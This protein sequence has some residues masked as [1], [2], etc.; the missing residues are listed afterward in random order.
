MPDENEAV[1][2]LRLLTLPPDSLEVQSLHPD[3]RALVQKVRPWIAGPNVVGTGVSFK[4]VAGTNTNEVALRVYVRRKIKHDHVSRTHRV[5]GQVTIPGLSA[6]LPTDV[7]EIGIVRLQ[8]LSTRQRPILPGYSVGLQG[9]STGSIACFVASANAPTVPLLLSNSHVLAEAGIAAAGGLVVQPGSDDGADANSVVGQLLKW[10]PFDF[11]AGFN[12]LCD[13][14]LASI[15]TG[16]DVINDIPTI[17][18][19]KPP[20]AVSA[21]KVG[22]AVQKTGRTTGHTT[23][24]VQDVHFQNTM[25]YPEP[26]GGSGNAGF[27]EQVLCSRYS[28][29]GD[30][31]SLICDMAGVAIG[32]HWAGSTA[33]SI[34]SPI[35]FVFQQLAVELWTQHP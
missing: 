33:A 22:D 1:Q 4:Q 27:H 12:N 13:A 5:P 24:V 25:F 8:A 20:A 6:P 23:G 9:G 26:G 11:T 15:A 17:G 28:E 32:L 2:A 35:Q 18:A 3:E 30:S 14:A 7:L 19:P 34:F 31:G 10:V 16:I 21:V 29:G